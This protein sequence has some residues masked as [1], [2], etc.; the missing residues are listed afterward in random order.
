MGKPKHSKSLF[1]F[2]KYRWYLQALNTKIAEYKKIN[3]DIA[4][5]LMSRDTVDDNWQRKLKREIRQLKKRLNYIEFT[6][7]SL[8]ETAELLPCKLFLQLHFILGL[9]LTE[10]AEK[11]NVSISTVRRIRDRA[12]R[13]FEDVPFEYKTD[14]E[15]S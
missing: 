5:G 12:E 15:L 2:E 11:M 8:P 3:S 1:Y 4:S 14:E 9:N 13:H 6:V 7:N 10:T